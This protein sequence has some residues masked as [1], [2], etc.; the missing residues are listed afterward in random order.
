[1][2][3][4]FLSHKLLYLHIKHKIH[5]NVNRIH[6]S[7][8]FK[9]LQHHVVLMSNTLTHTLQSRRQLHLQAILTRDQ[10]LHHQL[11]KARASV[12]V[13]PVAITVLIVL[14]PLAVVLVAIATAQHRLV[15]CHME[16]LIDTLTSVSKF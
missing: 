12:K 10:K 8:L 6:A 16:Q 15:V 9:I 2:S 14:Q 5:I 3:F 13:V 4:S 7:I 1:M 11:I